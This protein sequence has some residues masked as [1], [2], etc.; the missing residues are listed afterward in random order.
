MYQFA[1]VELFLWFSYAVD[2]LKQLKDKFC[3]DE[4]ALEVLFDEVCCSYSSIMFCKL[5]F[6]FLIHMG[7]LDLIIE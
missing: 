2:L 7:I 4:L 5:F 3:N 1:Y 6:F